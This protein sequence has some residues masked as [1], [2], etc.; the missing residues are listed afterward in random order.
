MEE[1]LFDSMNTFNLLN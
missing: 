1:V